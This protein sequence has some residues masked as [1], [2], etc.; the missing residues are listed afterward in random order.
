M[1]NFEKHLPRLK[2]IFEE[3]IK[4]YPRSEKVH[5][6]LIHYIGVLYVDTH[7]QFP[8]PEPLPPA[9]VATIQLK[10]SLILSALNDIEKAIELLKKMDA[11]AK[12]D[13]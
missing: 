4:L 9:I 8:I 2:K 6:N 1:N 7:F 10:E 11:R 5:Q 12:N 13:T 3:S